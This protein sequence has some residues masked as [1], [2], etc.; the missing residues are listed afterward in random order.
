MDLMAAFVL[1]FAL[2]RLYR[3]GLK[4][5]KRRPSPGAGPWSPR[6]LSHGPWK[7]QDRAMA[8]GCNRGFHYSVRLTLRPDF[9]QANRPMSLVLLVEVVRL[10]GCFF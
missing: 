6:F 2:L 5:L 1:H 3:N 7:I 10:F 8:N 4:A 9:E